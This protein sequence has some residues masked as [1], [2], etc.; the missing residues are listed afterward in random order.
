MVHDEEDDGAA[1]EA[2][3]AAEAF[4]SERRLLQQPFLP[5]IVHAA[6][7]EYQ[8][9]RRTVAGQ[10]SGPRVGLAQRRHHRLAQHQVLLYRLHVLPVP[11]EKQQYR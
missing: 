6:A 9:G 4:W 11:A 1:A 7:E 2:S 3:A 5:A 8:I 10:L